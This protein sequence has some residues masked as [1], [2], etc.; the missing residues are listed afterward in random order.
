MLFYECKQKLYLTLEA[1]RLVS[2]LRRYVIDRVLD[3]A[4]RDEINRWMIV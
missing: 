2:Q 1:A 4:I 3:D